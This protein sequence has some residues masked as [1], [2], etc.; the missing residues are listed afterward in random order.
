MSNSEIFDDTGLMDIGLSTTKEIN[1][2]SGI[3][4]IG[5][6]GTSLLFQIINFIILFLLLKKFLFKPAGKYLEDRRAKIEE[7]LI[8]ASDIAKQKQ[9]WETQKQKILAEIDKK[10][11]K[12]I[13]EAKASSQNIKLE[14][15][16]QTQVE[17]K[18]I[19]ERAKKE[20]ETAKEKMLIDARKDLSSIALEI[21]RKAVGS[22]INDKNNSEIISETVRSFK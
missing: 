17:Q 4:S 7:S 5:I 12:I 22:I 8:N 11:D 19:V 15:I 21:T 3:A 20:I 1:S 16:T 2:G 9:E 13:A 10:S 6:N 18:K 14:S